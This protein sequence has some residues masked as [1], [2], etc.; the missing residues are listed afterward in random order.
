[1]PDPPT[2]GARR[3]PPPARWLTPPRVGLFPPP[4]CLRL[5]VPPCDSPLFLWKSLSVAMAL[6]A[7]PLGAPAAGAH[8]A[9]LAL[10]PPQDP[11]RGEPREPQDDRADD[12]AGH[13][14]ASRRSALGIGRNTIHATQTSTSAATTVH[15]PHVP[16]PASRPNWYAF[17]AST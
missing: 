5:S 3:A 13:H 17:S 1:M 12:R 4:P 2:R 8:R 9:E 11:P 14:A 7:P 6:P 16:L 15:A 10:G